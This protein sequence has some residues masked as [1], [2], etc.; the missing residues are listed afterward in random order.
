MK[1]KDIRSLTT[2]QMLEKEKQ[3]KE[4]LF[5]LRFQN[6]TGSLEKSHLIKAVKKDIARTET[7][8]N[9]RSLTADD[10]AAAEGDE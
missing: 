4:E 8:I 5:N 9:E 7:I 6:A 10:S 1:A 3:Y 2:D